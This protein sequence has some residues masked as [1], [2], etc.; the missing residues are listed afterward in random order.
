MRRKTLFYTVNLIIPC[1]GISFLTVLTFYLPSDSGEKVRHIFDSLT[2][3]KKFSIE[4]NLK[5]ISFIYNICH[6]QIFKKLS[7]FEILAFFNREWW[8]MLKTI[9]SCY[10]MLAR[11]GWLH[12]TLHWFNFRGTDQKMAL[13]AFY[14]I[15][16]HRTC[17]PQ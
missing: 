7:I 1:M 2:H 15:N 10:G 3:F 9:F 4:K 8:L 12:D 13:K 6:V 16:D 5:R 17:R 11:I 14:S